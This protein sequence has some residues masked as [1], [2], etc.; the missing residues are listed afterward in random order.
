M[1]Q[2]RCSVSQGHLFDKIDKFPPRPGF[3]SSARPHY[4]LF[5]F[6]TFFCLLVFNSFPSCRVQYSVHGLYMLTHG[7]QAGQCLSI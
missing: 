4:H 5:I 2:M 3:L 7:I 6:Y 1:V